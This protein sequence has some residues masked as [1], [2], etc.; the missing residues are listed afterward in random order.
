MVRMPLRMRRVVKEYADTF[1]MER[2][3]WQGTCA[4]WIHAVLRSFHRLTMKQYSASIKH[5]LLLYS[6]DRRFISLRPCAVNTS[7]FTWMF[8]VPDG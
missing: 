1:V 5:G 8:S 4:P 3:L 7:E 2:T 6:V